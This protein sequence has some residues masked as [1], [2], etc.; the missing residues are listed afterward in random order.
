M[1]ALK[2]KALGHYNIHP[3]YRCRF[4]LSAGCYRASALHLIYLRTKNRPQLLAQWIDLILTIVDGTK[5]QGR[6]ST[7]I[8]AAPAEL[9]PISTPPQ[10]ITTRPSDA[11]LPKA[12]MANPLQPTTLVFFFPELANQ[13]VPEK[14]P[15]VYPRR[16]PANYF[17]AENVYTGER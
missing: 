5:M 16:S 6:R 1:K 4:L 2:T 10:S 15:A 11:A 17:Y 12:L 7:C 9:S 3:L 8:V 13:G 14:V